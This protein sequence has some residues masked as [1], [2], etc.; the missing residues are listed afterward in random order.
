MLHKAIL[1]K[2]VESIKL[3]VKQG[4]SAKESDTWEYPETERRKQL[5]S[6][7]HQLSEWWYGVEILLKLAKI[8]YPLGLP[9]VMTL[10]GKFTNASGVPEPL[11]MKW[12]E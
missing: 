2:Q 12:T 9:S 4:E 5:A 3:R 8:Y 7:S 11:R 10:K 1:R 6:P